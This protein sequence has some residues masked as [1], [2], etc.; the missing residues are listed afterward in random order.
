MIELFAANGRG[1]DAAGEKSLI[2]SGQWRQQTVVSAGPKAISM[3][4]VKNPESIRDSGINFLMFIYPSPGVTVTYSR[5]SDEG[6][7]FCFPLAFINSS[8]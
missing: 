1:A 5:S 7:L 8:Y 3:L 2:G 4:Q 6:N